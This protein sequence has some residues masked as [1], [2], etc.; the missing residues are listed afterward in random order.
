MCINTVGVSS[1]GDGVHIV[2]RDFYNYILGNLRTLDFHIFSVI[3]S[4]SNHRT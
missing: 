3:L 1:W 4:S 2:L